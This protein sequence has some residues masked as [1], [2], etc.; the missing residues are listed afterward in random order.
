MLRALKFFSLFE[1]MPSNVKKF[2]TIGE[3]GCAQNL[4]PYQVRATL[5]LFSSEQVTVSMEDICNGACSQLKTVLSTALFLGDQVISVAGNPLPCFNWSTICTPF[6][7]RKITSHIVLPRSRHTHACTAR[8][9]QVFF[10]P[11]SN[12][13]SKRI[14]CCAGSDSEL[15]TA[16]ITG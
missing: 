3:I 7:W 6:W 16:R 15:S 1:E 5:Y 9:L 2:W 8:V 13:Y 12:G 10:Q 11:P 4:K 14:P